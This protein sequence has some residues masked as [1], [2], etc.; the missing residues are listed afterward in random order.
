MKIYVVTH[1]KVNNKIPENYSF[2]Q[3]NAIKNGKNYDL[4]DADYEDN[5]SLKNPYYCE[6]TAA[7]SIWKNDKEND[8]VGLVHYRRFFVKNRLFTSYKHYLS[9]K[10]ITKDLKNY[11][12]IS[13]KLY[14]IP[15]TNKEHLMDSVYEKDYDYLRE[16]ISNVYNEYLETFDEVMK[17]NKTYLLNMFIT[18]KENWD[19]YYEWLFRIFDSMEQKVDMTGY[20]DREKRLYGFLSERLFT[21]YVLHNSLKVKSYPCIIVGES[22][23]KILRQK[24]ARKFKVFHYNFQSKRTKK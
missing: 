13:T 9:E 12:F 23:I 10:Q 4:T 14:M 20:S 15:C 1:K 5:I 6:L 8:V 11:D 19:K 3:V 24:I 21:V 22:K 17:D 2:I 7:Y 16:T 18:K